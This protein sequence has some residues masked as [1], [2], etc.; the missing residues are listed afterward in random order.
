MPDPP[1]KSGLRLYVKPS[2]KATITILPNGALLPDSFV[3]GCTL[4]HLIGIY[5]PCAS[6]PLWSSP[7][8]AVIGGYIP[9]LLA[10]Q[11]TYS[12]ITS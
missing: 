9:L 5:V 6:Y 4:H 10:V 12:C 11:V 2:S 8:K 3:V 1:A 7:A